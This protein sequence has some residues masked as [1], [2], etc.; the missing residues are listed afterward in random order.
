MTKILIALCLTAVTAAAQ[1]AAKVTPLIKGGRMVTISADSEYATD[2]RVKQA[3]FI[4]EP[5]REQLLR[6]GDLLES[7]ELRPVVDTVLPL[8]QASAAFTG[9]VKGRRGRGKLVATL[10]PDTRPC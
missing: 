3:Y 5:N 7:G 10:T 2:E 6:I 9:G 8:A 4:V 1:E